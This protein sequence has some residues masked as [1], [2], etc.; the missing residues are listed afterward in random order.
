MVVK[1]KGRVN[2]LAYVD[3]INLDLGWEG[4]YPL[5][6][7]LGELLEMRLQ[8]TRERQAMELD[9]APSESDDSDSSSESS[10]SSSDDDE[11]NGQGEEG[12]EQS[13][14]HTSD[15][16]KGS[17]KRRKIESVWNHEPH[18]GI[19]RALQRRNQN[20]LRMDRVGNVMVPKYTAKTLLYYYQG[21]THV[22][23][24]RIGEIDFILDTTITDEC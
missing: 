16:D 24:W 18:A 8:S 12:D 15:E 11:D 5:D 10:S 9:E 1:I 3:H 20:L 2:K 22:G 17:S 21:S 7:T 6:T 4:P 23:L 14:D 13:V 19:V